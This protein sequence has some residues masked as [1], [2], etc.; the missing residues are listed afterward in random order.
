MNTTYKTLLAKSTGYV[1]HKDTAKQNTGNLVFS[2]L[3]S[4]N[5]KSYY[6]LLAHEERVIIFYSHETG[7]FKIRATPVS[8]DPKHTK[9]ISGE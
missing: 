6:N 3:I 8:Q 2:D 5:S 1:T 9:E 7:Q 4:Q